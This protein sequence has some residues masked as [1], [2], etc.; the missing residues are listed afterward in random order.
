LVIAFTP[1]KSKPVAKAAKTIE[2]HQKGIMNSIDPGI[3]NG[4]LEKINNIVKFLKV[5]AR[6][7]RNS[8]NFTTMICLRQEFLHS[9]LP[10]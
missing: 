1:H 2:R 6:G 7:Y 5:G 9:R 8:S 3:S 4:V 10:P